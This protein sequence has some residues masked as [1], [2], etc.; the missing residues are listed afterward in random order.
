MALSDNPFV[1][2]PLADLIARRALWLQALDDIA[3]VGRST[4]FPG[5]SITRADLPGI[6]DTLKLLRVAIDVGGGGVAGAGHQIAQ[7]TINTS[8]KFTGR[9]P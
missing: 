4:A 5:L 6:L 9:A 8:R 3:K 7:V 2:L 1:G